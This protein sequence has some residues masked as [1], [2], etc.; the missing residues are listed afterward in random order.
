MIKRC[1][2]VLVSTVLLLG[3]A[4]AQAEQPL[5]A[6]DEHYV[7]GDTGE[8]PAPDL[9]AYSA[10]IKPLGGDSVRQCNG[11]P[12]IG[13]VEDHYPDGTLKHRGY[14]DAGQITVYRNYFPDGTLERDFRGID[15]VKSVMRTYHRNAQPRSEARYADGVAYQYKD[16]YVSGQLRYEEERDR[17]AAYF[18][19]MDLYAADGQPI[20]LLHQVDRKKA[21]FEQKEY[22]PG[23][24]LKSS[25]H[26]CYNPARMDSQ[27]IGTWTY[28]DTAGR[29][30]REEDY[31]DGKVHTA[32]DL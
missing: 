24:A 13:W 11:H 1:S 4:A 12:C 26:S 22:F 14:Y 8:D 18:I 7:M 31:V 27:R 16:Y 9:N 20:S 6:Q 29:L 10:L 2:L 23:G 28:Y 3:H 21:E 25:G 5:L 15:D 17:D 32:R 30:I 19:R